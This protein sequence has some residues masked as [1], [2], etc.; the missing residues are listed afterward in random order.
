MN[1]LLWRHAEAVDAV[2]SN[3]LQRALTVHGQEQAQQMALWL[4]PRLKRDARILVSPALRTQQTV[5]ALTNQYQTMEALAPGQTARNLLSCIQQQ[6]QHHTLI[7][8]GHQPTLGQ[9]A[10]LLM[11]G[12]ESAWSI[13]KGAVWWLK[14]RQ[15]EILEQ[16][17]GQASL[18][19]IVSTDLLNAPAQTQSNG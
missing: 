4:K 9:T 12:S 6:A 1:L 14:L 19:T 18:Y 7:I 10:S 15:P 5:R 3:D 17:L 16:A 8:V 11:T 13:K 2:G